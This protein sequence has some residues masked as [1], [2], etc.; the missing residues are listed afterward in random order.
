[1]INE[2]IEM[3]KNYSKYVAAPRKCSVHENRILET[4][5]RKINPD[6]GHQKAPSSQ[7]IKHLLTIGNLTQTV[8][9]TENSPHI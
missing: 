7:N 1:M 3:N 5:S 8:C 4:K 9:L 6:S 2:E